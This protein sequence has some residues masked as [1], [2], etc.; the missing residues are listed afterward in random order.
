MTIQNNKVITINYVLK[1]DQGVLID[2]SKDSS[3]CYLHGANNIIPGMEDALTGRDRGDKFN[4]VVEPADAYGEYNPN[5]TQVVDRSMFEGNDDIQAGMQ[6]QAQDDQGHFMIITI[7]KV[8]GDEITIDGN[9]PLAGTTL[10]YDIEVMDIRDATDEE[11]SHGH[12]QQHGHSRA[13]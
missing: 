9:H 6:F 1:D 2:E 7:A 3:F 4:L 5:L 8:D 13:H 11:L 12:V 10:H